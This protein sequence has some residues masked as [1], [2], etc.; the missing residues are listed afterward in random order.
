VVKPFVWLLGESTNALLKLLRVKVND[1]PQITEEEVGVLL[2]QGALAGIFHPEEQMITQRLFDLADDRVSALMTPRPDV[3]WIDAN[4]SP[5]EIR[6]K[7]E[8]HP[9]SR[10]PV[11]EGSLDNIVGVVS[12]R[13]LLLRPETMLWSLPTSFEPFTAVPESTMAFAALER[14]RQTGQHLTMVIDEYGGIAGILTITDILEALVGDIAEPGDPLREYSFKRPDGSWLIDGSL[15]ADD[16]ARLLDL[17]ELPGE[18]EGVFETA[19]G[20][21]LSQLGHIP[22]S[23]DS[24]QVSGWRFEVMDMDGRRVDKLLVTPVEDDES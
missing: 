23:G 18:L 4:A 20:F 10:Y 16:L 1:E 15:A 8:Q 9:H 6:A 3:V 13:E 19:A 2:Q 11:G 7:V 21:V 17:R 12:L 22:L 14:F 5:E 24:F